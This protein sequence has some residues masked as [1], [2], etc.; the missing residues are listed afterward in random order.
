VSERYL[1]TAD[2]VL[3][4]GE[5]ED[6]LELTAARV[7][8]L[9]PAPV[10][11]VRTKADLVSNSDQLARAEAAV[12]PA[13]GIEKRGDLVAD[14]DQISRPVSPTAPTPGGKEPTHLVPESYYISD[15]ASATGSAGDRA[16][17]PTVSVSAA[18][19]AGLGALAAALGKLLSE[20][21]GGAGGDQ[22]AGVHGDHAAPLLTRERHRIAVER[23]R[24]EV[25]DFARAWRDGS[26]PATVAAVHLHAASAALESLIGGVDVEDVLDRIFNDFCVGK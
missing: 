15:P 23:A 13:T 22:R 16:A 19:G 25:A 24:C 10:V 7:G 12:A 14:S 3:A 5:T 2:A 17:S 20:R 6:S 8:E 21:Y 4:C 1:A 18:T 11:R 9:T 26:L